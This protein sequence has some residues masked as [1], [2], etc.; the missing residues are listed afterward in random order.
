MRPNEQSFPATMLI[1]DYD[2]EEESFVKTTTG[3]PWMPVSVDP[4]NISSQL[5]SDSRWK[6][7]I[8]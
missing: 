2:L 4:N 5:F 8:D 6:T 1:M 7:V 3:A